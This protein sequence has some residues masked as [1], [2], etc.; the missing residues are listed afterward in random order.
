[1]SDG[2]IEEAKPKDDPEEF[3]SNKLVN[4]EDL[5]VALDNI[6]I[7]PDKFDDNSIPASKLPSSVLAA[8][9][10]AETNIQQ[11]KSQYG[12][13]LSRLNSLDQDVEDAISKANSA[14]SKADSAS[15]KADSAYDEAESAATTATNAAIAASNAATAATN[16]N[17]N[18]NG[19]VSKSGDTITGG[20]TINGGLAVGGNVRNTSSQAPLAIVE[21]SGNTV[22]IAA[23]SNNQWTLTPSKSGYTFIGVIGFNMKSPF[24]IP[25]RI[26]KSGNNLIVDVKSLASGSALNCTPTIYCLF[27]LSTFV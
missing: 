5:K 23:G 1:M 8:L 15:S 17:N 18:A 22:S 12:E 20:L 26:Y 27:A 10:A 25:D 4:L 16:A 13:A 19:R 14:S 7:S 3:G 21:I 6:K 24:L 9:Y 2:F 11:L